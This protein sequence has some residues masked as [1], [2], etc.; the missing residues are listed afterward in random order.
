MHRTLSYC[1]ALGLGMS[2]MAWAGAGTPPP[3]HKP[4]PAITIDKPVRGEAAIKATGSR[5]PELAAWYGKSTAEFARL[6][7][8]DR[9]LWLDTRGRAYFVD[10]GLAM[11]QGATTIPGGETVAG[12]LATW[13][14][15]PL[16]HSKPGANRV[17]YLDFDGATISGTAWNSSYNIPA[18]DA[19]PYDTDGN[20]SALSDA[21]LQNILSIWQRVAEDYAPFDVDVTTEQPASDALTRSTSSDITFGTS[22]IVTEDWTAAVSP[23]NCGG[24]AYLRAFDDTSEYYKPAWVFF[25]NLGNSHEK[26]VAEAISHEAGHNLGLNHDGDSST[27][28]YAGH[29]S[30]ATGWAPIMGVGYYRELTQWSKGEYPNANNQEDDFAVI[31]S[32]GAPIRADDHGNDMA[33]STDLSSSVTDGIQT[34]TGSGIIG[35]R[36]D[37]DIFRFNSGSG[38]VSVN[39]DAYDKGPNLDISLGLYDANGN[40]IASSN[41]VDG[42]G[43]NITY[44]A[45]AGLYFIRVDGTGKGTTTTG[46]SD[47]GSLGQYTISASAPATDGSAANNAPVAQFTATPTSGAAPLTVQFTNSSYDPDSDPLSYSWNFGDGSTSTAGSPA[48]LY[49]AAGSYLVSLT[50]TDAS[51]AQDS[52]ETTITVSPAAVVHIGNITMAKTTKSR[53]VRATATVPVLNA[54]G[55]PVAGATVTGKWSGIVSGTS[56][57]VT[58]STG[59]VK[60][61]SPSTSKTSGTFTFTVTGVTVSGYTYDSAQ[62]VETSESIAR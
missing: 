51:G 9:D 8:Q 18:I 20:P 42:L 46:Y 14:Q 28:Y 61:T 25:D 16:L 10:Q 26:Y 59:T 37:V 24:F 5:L 60:L 13:D 23:C 41:P 44:A 38:A 43:A 53:N 11:P 40:L 35:M 32:Y 22:V 30:G 47:Y 57:G 33:S 55:N 58:G 31:Q 39:L 36:T 29:G 3:S 34:L 54:S 48:H 7:R 19:K 50:V 62:N 45:G 12:A 56:S 1:L 4:F 52:V 15:L 17:I 27:G 2:A 6:I 49:S 21:E